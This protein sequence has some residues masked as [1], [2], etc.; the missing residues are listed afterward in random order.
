M[1]ALTLASESPRRLA[2]LAQA[3][4]VPDRVC[5]A[6]IDETPRPG[7][8]PRDYA[9]RLAAEKAEFVINSFGISGGLVLAADTVVACGR[10]ILP[11]AVDK[12]AVEACLN[13]LSGRRHMVLTA[14]AVA[15]PGGFTRRR[16]VATRVSFRRLN[17]EEI[18]VYIASGEGVGKAGGYA[19]QGRAEC[20]VQALNGPYS[21]VVGLPLSATVTLLRGCG[22]SFPC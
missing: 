8:L 3:G 1:P 20:F 17:A 2:L 11:K 14:V 7:E 16:V 6:G 12:I 9:L 10:R 15:A 5:A 19:I 22:Y 18:A 21:N 13:M 4:I